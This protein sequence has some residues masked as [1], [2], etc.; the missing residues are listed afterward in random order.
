MNTFKLIAAVA[1]LTASLAS[2]RR[3]ETCR[4]VNNGTTTYE[5][6]A[7][8]NKDVRDSNQ[9]ACEDQA[10]IYGGTCTCEKS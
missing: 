6:K 10:A 4:V 3:C 8:G 5:G 2:C 9:R 7:C 1:V